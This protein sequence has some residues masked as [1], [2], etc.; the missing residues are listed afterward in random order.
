MPHKPSPPTLTGPTLSAAEAIAALGV[1]RPTLYAYVSRGLIR[2]E[3]AEADPRRRRYHAEDVARLVERQRQRR[4]PARA[5]ATALRWGAPVLESALT[6]ITEGGLYYRGHSAVRL[7][8]TQPL[9][10]VA[11]LLWGGQLAPAVRF[12]G[13]GWPKPVTRALA[14]GEGLTPVA[15]MQAV[16]PAAA[17]ADVL[18]N[19][20]RP[21]SVLRSAA[22]LMGL[23]TEAA[24]GVG[25]GDGLAAALQQTWAPGQ[26]AARPALSA[27]LVLCADH[28]LNVSAFAARC[29]AS[30]GA[31]P[32][33]VVAAGL[34]ALQGVRHG[35]QTERVEALLAQA[36]TAAEARAAVRRHLRRGERV[37]G[38]GHALYPAGDPRGAELLRQAAAVSPRAAA[39]P[40]AVVDEV[41]TLTGER[42]TVDFG[43]VALARA[44]RLPPGS[45]LTLFA[46]GRAVG[47]LGHA[48]EQ[49][50]ANHLIRP[51]ARYV[52]VA[53]V[54]EN[55]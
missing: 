29:V 22:R 28:E 11:A 41:R 18:A 10:A 14:A 26:T 8:R 21:A 17:E 33:A 44:L 12:A 38:F 37:P 43:L 54:V 7:A 25:A 3:A 19:D 15:R 34:A 51:R 9:E 6:L 53:P 2:S 23:L 32:Y 45:A 5:A 24:V 49:Y 4:D 40:E 16:L 47:W 20:L 27:A 30:A 48:L 52:G 35:G 13:A 50:A 46:L 42:P 1:A 39:L 55:D 31:S 36:R